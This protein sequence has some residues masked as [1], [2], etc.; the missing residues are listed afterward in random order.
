MKDFTRLF[1]IL[2]Y[3]N[4]NFPQEICLAGKNQGNW[5]KYSTQQVVDATNQLS[6]GLMKYG[7]Q[8][9]DKI[10]I[11]STNNR[12]EWNFVDLATLQI[13]AVDVPIYPTISP[14][15]YQ[16][17]MNDAKVRLVFVSDVEV[18][19]KVNSIRDQVPSL[20]NV[21]MFD[22]VDGVPH[23]SEIS[24]MGDDSLVAE[25]EARKAAID[26]M[27]LATLI[28]T[29][30]TTGKPKGVMLSHNNIV[31]NTKATTKDLPL[32]SGNVVLSFLPLCHIFERMV[33]YSYLARGAQIH[34]AESIETIGDNLKE[35]SP[36]FFTAVPRLLE[37]VF[38]KIVNK[39]LDL[40]GVKRGLF[41]WALDLGMQFDWREKKSW[42][43]NTKL[44]IAN[45]LIFSKWREA[46]G[47][48]VQGIVTGSA[49]LQPRLA[50][51]FSAGQIPVREG[52]GLTETSPVLTYNRFQ[53]DN[54]MIGTVGIPLENVEIKLDTDGE[55]LA[56]GPNVMMGYYNRPDAT[57]DVMTEDGWFRTGDIGEMIE[58]KFLKITDR[59]KQLMKTSNG[60]YVAPQPIEE[61]FKESMLIEQM[62]VVAE[63]KKFVSALIVPSFQNLTDWC[64]TKGKQFASIADMIGDDMVKKKFDEL[65]AE[66]NPN[67]SK[68]EQIKKYKLLPKEFTVEDGELTPTMKVKRKIITEKYNDV[69]ESIYA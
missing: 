28:Y 11:I 29:S 59:K 53:D 67:F 2:H 66:F 69:I 64:E 56:K 16:Y 33:T 61:K 20:E 57:A 21:Y 63:G 3:Q 43:Y 19:E 50:K 68:T 5:T 42:W 25:L 49:P 24:N 6:L 35:V 12:P 14:S 17:I 62:M 46:L 8:P 39:G 37:K 44:K 36:H 47:G 9:G 40:K 30:G 15:D 38:E 41:F 26:P 18:L 1:D 52:Y 34:Y 45:K 4:A 55:I 22:Q 32:K 7:I 27:E 13:G 58:G 60:K 51:V 65:C 48:R 54:A 10:G 23:Y 31:E